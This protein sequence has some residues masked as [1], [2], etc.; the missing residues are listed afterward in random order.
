MKVDRGF[1]NG[2]HF[3]TIKGT[4]VFLFYMPQLA[5]PSV[6]NKYSICC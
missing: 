5:K 1:T 4:A 3:V 6:N 2:N